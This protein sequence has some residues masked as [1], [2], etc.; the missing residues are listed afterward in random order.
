MITNPDLHLHTHYSDGLESPETVVSRAKAKGFD[1]IAV[2][3]H[4]GMGGVEAAVEAGRKL[5]IPVIRGIEFSAEFDN[6]D[7][8]FDAPQGMAYMHLLGYGMD[9]ENS[10][11]KEMLEFIRAN[12][13]E[14]NLKLQRIF[15]YLGYPMSMKE[16]ESHALNGFVGKRSFAQIL[17]ERG[18]CKTVSD[19]FRSEK[20]LRH[21]EIRKIHMYKIPAQEAIKI[22]RGAGGKV[23]FAHPFQLSYSTSHEDSQ[24][25]YEANIERVIKS[26]KSLGMEGIECYYP[27]HSPEQT[28]FLLDMAKRLGM[29]VS[30]GSDDHGEGARPV[31]QMGNFSVSPD[32]SVLQWIEDFV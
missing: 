18:A 25:V 11:L 4:D 8:K 14:R 17:V 15:E 28:A 16:L 2:T 30:R 31:K 29:L 24:A 6:T 9:P 1:V 27:T 19:A 5:G 21:P 7:G 12:R 20:F 22:V 32:L 3:D 13:V 10:A 26:L 23:F